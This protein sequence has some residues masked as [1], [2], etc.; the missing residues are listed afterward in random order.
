MAAERF[1]LVVIGAGPGGYVA[2]IRAAQL[3]MRVAC[4][5]KERTLGGTCLNVGCIPSKALLDSSELYRQALHGLGAHGIAANGVTLDLA[6]MMARKDKVV[7]GLTQ[8]VASLFKKNKIAWV[9]GTARLAGPREVV[10]RGGQGERTLGA[11]RVLI[12]TGSEPTPL[13]GLPFDGERI[14]SSTEAL[15]FPAVPGRMLIIGA[16]AVGLEL[17]SVWS[18]LGAQVTVVEFLDAIVPSM[19]R[20]MATQLQR[21][22]ERQGLTFRL[23]TEARGAERSTGG[24][25]V[26]LVSKKGETA[27]EE[28]DVVLVAVGRRPYV[29]GLGTG[30]IGVA[31]DERGRIRASERFETSVPGVFAIGD[32]IAGP[33]LAHKAQEEGVAAVEG[34][35]G[36]GGHVNYDAIPNIVYTWPELASVGLSEEDAARRGQ[37]VRVGSF[38]FLANGRAR[39]MNETEGSVKVLA[40]AHSDRVVGLHILG[41]RASDLI[42]EAALAVEF[43][44]SAEDVARTV[45]AHPTLS[46]AVKEAA[47]AMAKRAIHI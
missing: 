24:V 47:L 16:G 29:E 34:M 40:D 8:G 10:V 6:T 38:P 14:V 3:G 32:V 26:T 33:M 35:A 25:R 44:A 4:V 37:E 9:D 30:E 45:H 19:D 28:V 13:R 2:A 21:A 17:G 5:E 11:D 1:D 42:A 39:C 46:E 22:L 18:R 12:A 15:T 7:R 31:L 20:G 23:A 36:Q 41:P 43:G 27:V